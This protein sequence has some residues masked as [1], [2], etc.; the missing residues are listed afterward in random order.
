MHRRGRPEPQPGQRCHT[1]DPGCANAYVRVRTWNFGDDC[2]NTS[3]DFVQTITVKDNTAPIISTVAGALDQTLECSN[4]TDIADALLLVPEATDNCT[5]VADLNLNLVSD[6]T[7][8]DGTC[9]NAYVRVRTWNF[10][11]D[12]GNTSS[13]FVQ[14]ITVKDNTAPVISTLAGALD[15]TLEC[16]NTTDIADALLLV[17][18]ATDN[19]TAVADLNLNLVSDVTTPDGTCANAYVR[20]RTWNFD[21]DCGNTSANFVQTI[22]VKDNTAPVIST[23]AGALDKT[24]ECSNTTDIADALLLVPEATDNCTAVADLNLNLVS[25]VTTAD[26]GCA[27][28]YVRVR[29]WNFGD[30]CGNTSLD[31]V[32]TI[33]VEDNTAP[34]LTGTWPSNQTGLDLCYSNVPAGPTEAEIAVLYDDNCSSTI[35]VTKSGTPTGNDAGWSV[36]YS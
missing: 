19:C 13:D 10:D 4:T 1:A 35:T 26:P 21:D 30:D 17:P 20:V 29:T 8:P 34:V 32:Q 6:V 18:E 11:D 2:G 25:D 36:T 31:F 27:N 33:T 22:T 9:A 12:C 24:L 7:T 28:A 23:L 15:K 16:S 14:T 3:L 5:A